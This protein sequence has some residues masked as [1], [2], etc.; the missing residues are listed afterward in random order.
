MAIMG[1]DNGP[2]TARQRNDGGLRPR[3]ATNCEPPFRQFVTPAKM[4][5][6]EVKINFL[7]SP[8]QL[9]LMDT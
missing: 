4:A 3:E 2:A 9:K 5:Q 6:N 1:I 8:T 7:R